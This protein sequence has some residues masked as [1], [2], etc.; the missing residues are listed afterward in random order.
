MSGSR[1]LKCTKFGKALKSSVESAQSIIVAG[2]VEQIFEIQNTGN[3]V[4]SVLI[5][6]F[7]L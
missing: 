2:A 5:V 6:T 3:L 7:G 4:Q 1:H